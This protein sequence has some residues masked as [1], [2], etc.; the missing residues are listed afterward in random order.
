MIHYL[1]NVRLAVSAKSSIATSCK[2]FVNVREIS[3]LRRHPDESRRCHCTVQV[4]GETA[5]AV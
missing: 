1:P 3:A 4:I 2:T 5:G